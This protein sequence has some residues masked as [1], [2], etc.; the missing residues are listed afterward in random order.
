VFRNNYMYSSFKEFCLLET[1]W[2]DSSEF[3]CKN[4]H[5]HLLNFLFS[6]QPPHQM[7]TQP[8][9]SDLVTNPY[10]TKLNMKLLSSKMIMALIIH[11]NSYNSFKMWQMWLKTFKYTCHDKQF[12]FLFENLH[13]CEKYIWKGIL[14]FIYYFFWE[15]KSLDLKKIKNHVTAFPLL[16]LIW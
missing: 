3:G 14:F 1:R 7:C 8:H 5:I 4:I 9:S 16:V 10:L 2:D 13:S 6:L 11:K 15:K 12:Y